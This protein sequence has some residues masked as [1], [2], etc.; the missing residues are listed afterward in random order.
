MMYM[1]DRCQFL[2][3]TEN[4]IYERK[5]KKVVHRMVVDSTDGGDY[6]GKPELVN[7]YI[8]QIKSP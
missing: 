7:V 8:M 2:I 1:D 3:I 5:G 6:L 4:R